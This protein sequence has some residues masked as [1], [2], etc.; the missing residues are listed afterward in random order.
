[1]DFTES[2]AKYPGTFYWDFHRADLHRCLLERAEEL[3]AEIRCNSRVVDV[4]ICDGGGRARAVLW[5][6]EKLEGDLVVGAD[7]VNSR[8]REVMLGKEDPP[9]ETGDLAYRLLLRTEG[10]L[11]EEDL[12]GFVEDPQVNYWL[13]PDMHAGDCLV[14]KFEWC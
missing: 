5:N 11:A 6:G 12:R 7:G 14:M 9:K 1:M 8:L 10:M 4:E 13:G 2:A 3:G